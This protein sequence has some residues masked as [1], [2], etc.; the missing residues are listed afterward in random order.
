M[1]NSML[2]LRGIQT[3]FVLRSEGQKA[4]FSP[5]L[6]EVPSNGAFEDYLFDED[7]FVIKER[8]NG[9]DKKQVQELAKK[10][11]M[12]VRN[13]DWTGNIAMN[14]NA[15]DDANNIV[16]GYIDGKITEAVNDFRIFPDKLIHDVLVANGATFDGTAIFANS[17]TIGTNATFD[18]L[19][20]QTGT[21][22]AN[23]ITDLALMRSAIATVQWANNK[24]LIN[25]V[26]LGKWFVICPIQLYWIF[27]GIITKQQISTGVSNEWYQFFTPILNPYQDTSTNGWYMVYY[28]PG[29]EPFFLQKRKDVS[30]QM[31]DD[32]EQD[33][34][35][36]IAD[37]RY[38][39]A[40][41][42]F[43]SIASCGT[44]S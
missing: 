9:E 24:K 26:G 27:L 11:P 41:A 20:A 39:A 8:T 29:R 42:W 34:I 22:E 16:P 19:L 10:Y 28:R 30:W 14:R 43:T 35:K 25:P 33:D 36:W 40:P 32:I 17:H 6:R 5:M 13:R 12:S 37:A 3:A 7:G 38:A 15:Y 21:T 23:I 4:N 2:T 1:Q 18:N 31:K 44:I